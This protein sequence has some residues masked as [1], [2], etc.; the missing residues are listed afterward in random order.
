MKWLVIA[1]IFEIIT[2]GVEMYFD[3]YTE[4]CES[5]LADPQKFVFRNK[6]YTCFEPLLFSPTNHE[7]KDLKF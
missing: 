4:G 1:F 7:A 5:V 2:W 6:H 3:I